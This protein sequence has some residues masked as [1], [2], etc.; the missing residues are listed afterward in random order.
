LNGAL[1]LDPLVSGVLLAPLFFVLG[2]AVYRVYYVSFE[3][4]GESP[5]RGLV[6]FFG[7][8][9][10]IEVAL[11]LKFGVDY[12]L[13]EAPYIGE[14]IHLGP[15]GISYRLLVPCVVGLLMTLG[16]YLFL[17]HTFYGL[18]IMG[19]APHSL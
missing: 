6:F 10:I 13:V 12:R 17:G 16:I 2:V 1:G 9:F 3:S 14:S 8:L 15:I 5:L 4:K 18:A 19:V 7:L 11:I